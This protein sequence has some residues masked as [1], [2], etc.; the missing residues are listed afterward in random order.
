MRA[1][2][3]F[4]RQLLDTVPR[5]RRYARTLVFDAGSADALGHQ[6]L[7]GAR[8]HAN[9]QAGIDQRDDERHGDQKQAKQHQAAQRLR[10]GP[11]HGRP[12]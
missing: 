2:D 12:L 11:P 8:E 1:P 9:L 7:A 3:T 5:L 10:T 6:L 4:C